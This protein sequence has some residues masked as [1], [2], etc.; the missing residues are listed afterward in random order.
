MNF[1]KENGAL[2]LLLM[3]IFFVGGLALVF[4]GWSMTGKIPGLLIMIVG[5][6]LLLTALFLYNA[7]FQT[8]KQKHEKR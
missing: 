5:L 8:K 1:W 2:R 3:L 6:I 4:I 7:A